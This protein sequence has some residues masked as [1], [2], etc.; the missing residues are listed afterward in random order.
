MAEHLVWSDRVKRGE[1]VI[2]QDG[3]L[4]GSSPFEQ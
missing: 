2:E 3:D 1:S 4:Y